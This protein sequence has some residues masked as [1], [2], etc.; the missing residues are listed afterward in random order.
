MF[1]M[2]LLISA[3]G[4]VFPFAVCS[5][6]AIFNSLI[7]SRKTNQIATNSKKGNQ[8]DHMKLWFRVK[9]FRKT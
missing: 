3:S 8:V 1:V 4:L 5:N 2:K 9:Y 7:G 6:L